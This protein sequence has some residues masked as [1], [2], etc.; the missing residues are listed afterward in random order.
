MEE[1]QK[2]FTSGEIINHRPGKSVG[3]F[4]KRVS[5]KRQPRSRTPAA[6]KR[7]RGPGMGLRTAICVVLLM[8][9]V[10]LKL[11]DT[12]FSRTVLGYLNSVITYDMDFSEPF[13]ELKF[14]EEIF[15]PSADV[16]ARPAARYPMPMKGTVA[17]KEDGITITAQPGSEVCAIADG[18][19]IRRGTNTEKG[20]YV[21][22]DHGGGM[23]SCY[24]ALGTSPLKQGD[25]V[26]AGARVGTTLGS[27]LYFELYK[28]DTPVKAAQYLENSN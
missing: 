18:T 5:V 3:A 13:G 24:Y 7:G 14:V 19:V 26:T 1:K 28:N 15:H 20:N 8:A 4:S 17:E 6:K 2:G 25:G 9:A 10:Y 23:V 22:I 27:E 21:R 16:A 11:S 12:P